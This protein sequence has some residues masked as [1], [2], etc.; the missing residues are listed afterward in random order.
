MPLKC[1]RGWK[2]NQLN[3]FFFPEIID[4]IPEEERK[5]YLTFDDG[6]TPGITSQVLAFLSEYKAKA[7][8][9]CKGENAAAHPELFQEVHEEGHLTGNH[10]FLH[11]H[12]WYT[13]AVEYVNDCY[14]AA[15]I[16]K[17]PIFRPPFGKMRFAQYNLLKKTFKIYLWTALSWDFHP[18][19]SKE[20]CSKIVVKNLRPGAILV[21]HDTQKAFPALSYALPRLLEEGTNKGFSFSALPL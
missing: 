17:Y 16:I 14:K 3:K 11:L 12:G 2:V 13:P 4:F 18:W 20:Q 10:G 21:F 7:T 6:P 5:I 9:F 1:R 15:E 8:F 19:V